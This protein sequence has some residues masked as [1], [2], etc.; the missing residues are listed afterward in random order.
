MYNLFSDLS[1]TTDKV[2]PARINAP[3]LDRESRS[4]TCING[5]RKARTVPEHAPKVKL[6]KVLTGTTAAKTES[7][8]ALKKSNEKHIK[9]V[10]I[11]TN[12][13]TEV[14]QFDNITA[15]DPNENEDNENVI[16]KVEKNFGYSQEEDIQDYENEDVGDEDNDDTDIDDSMEV[17]EETSGEIVDEFGLNSK[18]KGNNA[19]GETGHRMKV[20]LQEVS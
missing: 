3:T 17:I 11:I 4:I 10:S 16:I 12:K 2:G 20:L 18:T 7:E 6:V 15:T 19:T 5:K 14:D 1:V 13:D 9:D 8:N